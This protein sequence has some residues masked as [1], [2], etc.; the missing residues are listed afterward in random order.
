MIFNPAIAISSLDGKFLCSAFSLYFGVQFGSDP[1][2]HN[3]PRPCLY[4]SLLP[5]PFPSML[6]SF[7]LGRICLLFHVDDLRAVFDFLGPRKFRHTPLG[8]EASRTA[9]RSLLASWR[10]KRKPPRSNKSIETRANHSS[11]TRFAVYLLESLSFSFF[12]PLHS[13]LL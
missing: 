11:L 10:Y 13:F 7:F 6:E 2:P 5:A 9:L 8:P 4:L 12:L 3:L 1:D